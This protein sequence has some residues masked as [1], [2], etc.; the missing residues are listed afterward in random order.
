MQ[1]DILSSDGDGT[2]LYP[3]GRTAVTVCKS[4]SGFFHTF[5]ADSDVF[6]V[7]CCFDTDGVGSVNYAQG[8]N[9]WLVTTK[10]GWM[11]CSKE[12]RIEQRGSWPRTANE[13]IM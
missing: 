12:G 9:P 8:G 7:L 6:Q 5:I 11:L 4:A 10:A 13:P 3:S 1:L 2:I